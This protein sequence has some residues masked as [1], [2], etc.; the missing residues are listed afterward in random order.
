MGLFSGLSNLL[1]TSNNFR[2]QPTANDFRASDVALDESSYADA[3]TRARD[4]AAGA[5]G[6]GNVGAQQTSLAQALQ[7]QMA[8]NGPSLAQRQ[9]ESGTQQIQS[10]AAGQ[11]AS[12]NGINPALQARMIG[13]NTANA[14]QQAAGQAA[15]TRLQEQLGTQGLLAQALQA[16]RGQDIA[17]QQANTALLGT[18][19]GLQQG[20]NQTR[21]QQNLGVAG[22]N[23]GVTE[24][25]ANRNLGAQQINAGVA[26]QN[27][28]TNAGLVGGLMQ[29]GGAIASL[30]SDERVKRSVVRH[31][32][33]VIDGVPRATFE[34]R[35][36]PGVRMEGVIAQDVEREHPE[37]VG[38]TDDG[39]RYVH[40][41]LAAHVAPPDAD[42]DFSRALM[43]QRVKGYAIGGEIYIPQLGVPDYSG[44]QYSRAGDALK[45]ALGGLKKKSPPPA[46]MPPLTASPLAANVPAGNPF[47][48]EN[49]PLQSSVPTDMNMP[50]VPPD[51]SRIPGVAHG[52]EIDFRDG[53]RVPGRAAVAGDDPRNDTVPAKVSPGEIVLP[54]SVAQAEDAPDQAAA[55]VDAIRRKR[56]PETGYGKVLAGQRALEARLAQIEIERR[57]APIAQR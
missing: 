39:V 4:A 27:A 7:A 16:Q 30:F 38:E 3:I 56:A 11:V 17:Q 51:F 10:Q 28:N 2:A 19:G 24:G 29:S 47:G 14:G 21:V 25:N 52:G 48:V 57:M 35:A 9:L 42:D 34:Y 18:A 1:G 13:Q 37:L 54:R 32:D 55:F 8:G 22:I 43:E 12:L 33:E 49:S 6:G 40:P 23:A 15:T 41:A 53:G 20:Q 26:A 31:P 36:A 44:A 45:D 5:A 46:D 50:W